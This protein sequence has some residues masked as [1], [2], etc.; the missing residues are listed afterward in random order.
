[1]C[2]GLTRCRLKR[3]SEGAEMPRKAP[4]TTPVF[5]PTPLTDRRR[6]QCSVP[7]G[8][9]RPS[10]RPGVPPD[11]PSRHN[12][13]PGCRSPSGRQRR[14]E[15]GL[16]S[17]VGG[18]GGGG[19]FGR[20]P[21]TPGCLGGGR[22][23]GNRRRL[24]RGRRRLACNRQDI[25]RAGCAGVRGFV[26]AFRTGQTGTQA[27]EPCGGGGGAVLHKARLPKVPRAPWLSTPSLSFTPPLAPGMYMMGRPRD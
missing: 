1:M 18:G 27:P 9:P 12:A 11:P 15:R 7:G 3:P 16:T 21:G 26:C 5:F 17:L 2:E 8:T 14:L 6:G 10:P 25:L 20:S 22:I 19:V 13:A 4:L 24:E 23:A